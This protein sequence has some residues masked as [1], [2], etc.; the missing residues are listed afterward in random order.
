VAEPTEEEKA[1]LREEM[2]REVIRRE[3][4]DRKKEA[5]ALEKIRARTRR[6]GKD[7]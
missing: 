3:N 7:G 6:K 2:Q 5:D 4:E 1:R